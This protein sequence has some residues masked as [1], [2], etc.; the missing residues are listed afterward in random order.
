MPKAGV[1]NS[2]DNRR[3][4]M[5]GF[6]F[7]TNLGTKDSVTD[8]KMRARKTNSVVEIPSGPANLTGD[9]NVPNP[10][11]GVVVMAGNGRMGRRNCVRQPVAHRLQ[12]EGLATLLTDLRTRRE[13]QAYERPTTFH[14]DVH[15]EASR[16]I[17]VTDWVLDQEDIK[18]LK[19]GFFAVDVAGAAALVAATARPN[20][21]GA[22]VACASRPDLAGLAVA[23]ARTP[24]LVVV[25]EQDLSTLALSRQALLH[26]RTEER[27]EI[28]AGAG[29]RFQEPE[30]LRQ[31]ADLAS[32]WFLKYLVA[33]NDMSSINSYV[34]ENHY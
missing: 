27:L 5:P 12:A 31:A 20:A 33:R 21:V 13:A 23:E 32:E 11:E 24:T 22:I 4:K 28:V 18:H 15:F 7:E 25:G 14:M 19:I 16:L 17:G 3:F 29:A 6:A 10:A 2:K 1:W 8:R 9:L 26:F 34:S 30:Q